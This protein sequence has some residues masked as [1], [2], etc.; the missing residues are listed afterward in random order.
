M[1]AEAE[2][3]GALTADKGELDGLPSPASAVSV[4]VRAAVLGLA[5]ERRR[6]SQ[7]TTADR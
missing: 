1:C 6:N 3:P 2:L 7:K 4:S 5:I